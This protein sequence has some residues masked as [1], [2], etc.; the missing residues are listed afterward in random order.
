[1]AARILSLSALVAFV[2]AKAFV[3]NMCDYPVYVWSVPN[4]G[5]AQVNG[6]RIDPKARYVERFRYGEGKSGVAIKVS[7]H[8]DGIY[9]GK[10]EIDFAYSIDPAFPNTA[11]WVDLSPVR[12]DA[13]NVTS[14]HYPWAVLDREVAPLKV[15]AYNNVELVLCST[16]RTSRPKDKIAFKY[17]S[18]CYDWHHGNH[19]TSTKSHLDGHPKTTTPYTDKPGQ[20]T[21]AK[22]TKHNTMTKEADGTTVTVTHTATYHEPPESTSESSGHDTPYSRP[23]LYTSAP[24]SNY[25]HGGRPDMSTR[26]TVQHDDDHVSRPTGYGDDRAFRR[27][28]L[29]EDTPWTVPEVNDEWCLPKIAW[30][31]PRPH[32]DGK[33]VK[34]NKQRDA[35]SMAAEKPKKCILPFC[36][37][38]KPDLDCGVVEKAFEER[39][40]DLVD[41]TEDDD[42]CYTFKHMQAHA[43]P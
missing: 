8:P 37:P 42:T 35:T 34:D 33:K 16:G 18:Q 40:L 11:I 31:A 41:W 7:T 17:I 25:A 22:P 10:D 5:K 12:G 39:D 29:A 38:A 20:I 21:T 26:H 3:T 14:F 36:T 43:S 4:I 24:A 13:F 30:T 23:P 2:Q 19:S 32:L 15:Y 1:M 9:T 6:W 28:A 27:G